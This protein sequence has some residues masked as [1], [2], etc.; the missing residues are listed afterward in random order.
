MEDRMDEYYLAVFRA[1]AGIG[2]SSTGVSTCDMWMATALRSPAAGDNKLAI[3]ARLRDRAQ[4]TWIVHLG[5]DNDPT[6]W[7]D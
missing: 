2:D 3:L 5:P 4:V 7:A 1:T 6:S